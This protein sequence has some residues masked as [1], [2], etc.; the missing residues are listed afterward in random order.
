M[1]VGAHNVA[2]VD[3]GLHHS[4][5]LVRLLGDAE[6]FHLVGAVV[7]VERL[8]VLAVAAIGTAS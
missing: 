7:E 2:L 6:E 1:A 5:G 3:L 4:P 8:S